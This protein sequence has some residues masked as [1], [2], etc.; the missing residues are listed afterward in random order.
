[1][2]ILFYEQWYDVFSNFSALAVEF[3]GV[4]YPTAEHA[5]QAAKCTDPAGKEA[6]RQAKSPAEAKDIANLAYQAARH[7]QWDDIKVGVLEQILR[8]KVAQH[9][10]VR[11]ALLRSGQEEIGEAS[12][13]DTF[14][15]YGDGKG[16]NQLGKLWMKIRGELVV[17]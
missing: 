6:I 11:Q 17:S 7:P 3:E 9:N 13:D 2:A 14:W 12:P 5:Y 1:M 15:G 8:A 10:V 4:L 16:Q